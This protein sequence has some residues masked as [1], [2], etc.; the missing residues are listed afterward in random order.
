MSIEH[1]LDEELK[2]ALRTK[3]RARLDVI[4][5]IRTEVTKAAAEPGAKDEDSD[6][7]HLRI[8]R[9]YVK[10]MEKAKSEYEGYGERGAEMVEKLGFETEYLS[11]W[12]PQQQ[13]DEDVA[14]LV[15]QAIEDTG[16]DDPKQAGRIIGMLMKQ[17]DGLDGG[18]V[19]RLVKEALGG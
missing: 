6:A 11:R 19:N 15:Q 10:K 9:S 12:L 3:D 17:H 18:T 2:D 13:S 14:R 7:R 5:Q 4:R 1:E 8:I 16:V